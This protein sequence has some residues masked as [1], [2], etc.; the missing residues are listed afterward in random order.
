MSDFWQCVSTY[1]TV[2]MADVLSW[3]MVFLLILNN[4]F[5]NDYL[6][7]VYVN[8]SSWVMG[9]LFCI[10]HLIDVF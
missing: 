6:P 4:N 3:C 5:Y 2:C 7:E 1:N 9:P 8:T 10:I